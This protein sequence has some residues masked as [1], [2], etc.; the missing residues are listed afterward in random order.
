MTLNEET[1][2]ALT[3]LKKMLMRQAGLLRDPLTASQS[4]MSRRQASGE[5]VSD[6]AVELQKLFTESYPG[7]VTTSLA[8]PDNTFTCV[9]CN[10]SCSTNQITA[11][12]LINIFGG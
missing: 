12:C 10:Y 4:F 1:R 9:R 6:F 8:A 11:L 2:G 7:E 5:K 3:E